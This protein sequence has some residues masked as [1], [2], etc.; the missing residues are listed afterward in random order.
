LAEA[1]EATAS[2]IALA[3][4]LHR[5]PNIL[6]IPGTTRAE[7][8]EANVAAEKVGLTKEDSAQLDGLGR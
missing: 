3:W 7:H 6:L 1:H 8:L 5:S 4:L 2:Q